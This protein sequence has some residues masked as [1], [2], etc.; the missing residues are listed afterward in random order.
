MGYSPQG[1]KESDTT[2]QLHFLSLS[3]PSSSGDQVLGE[4][5]CCKT[6][7]LPCPCRC[8]LG[9]QL[10]HLLR[11]MWTVQNPKKSWLAMKPACGKVDDSSLEP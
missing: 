10:A 5:G 6:Y 2:E 7:R 8:F 9:L 11:Q 3:G 1:R 4:H